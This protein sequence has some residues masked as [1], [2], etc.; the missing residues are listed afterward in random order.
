ML[1]RQL[2]YFAALAREQHFARA[3][4]AC[5]VSQPALSESLRKLERELGVPLVRR[6]SN[7]EGL[8]AEGE[9]LLRWTRRILADREAMRSEVT[10][11]RAGLRG[12]L[13]IGV[14]PAATASVAGMVDRFGRRHGMVDVRI[15]SGLTSAEIVEQVRT[16]E[17]EVGLVFTDAVDVDDVLLTPLYEEHHVLVVPPGL[18]D[19]KASTIDWD[20]VGE[21]P[22]CLLH[23]GMRGRDVLDEAAAMDGFHLRPR[24]ETDSVSTLLALVQTG[25]WASIVPRSQVVGDHGTP[26]LRTIDLPAP[27]LGKVAVIRS[28]R[29]PAPLLATALIDS[30]KSS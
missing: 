2:E 17:F 9:R 29:E 14:I 6:G 7:F 27:P 11:I 12:Q 23:K 25:H 16:F 21:L 5:H 4:A 24:V 3:A 28:A 13:R 20:A 8:T 26:A 10:D 30:L 19:H 18:I 1:F 22:L 15:H